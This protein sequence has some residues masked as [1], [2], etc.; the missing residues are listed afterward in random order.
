MDMTWTIK[1]GSIMG[2]WKQL[3]CQLQLANVFNELHI[4]RRSGFLNSG[5]AIAIYRRWDARVPLWPHA[6]VPACRR[7][8]VP[9][10]PHAAIDKCFSQA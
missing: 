3:A 7:A 9:P 8:R 5:I 4:W 1:I 6:A 10:W 2:R